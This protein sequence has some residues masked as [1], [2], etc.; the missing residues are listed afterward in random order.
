MDILCPEK[1]SMAVAVWHG[2]VG[3]EIV[4]RVFGLRDP[5]IKQAIYHHVLGDCYDPY[6][7]MVF[8]ADKT[9]PLRG[10]DST[11]MIE[12]CLQDLK[13]GFDIVKE[14]NENYLQKRRTD[15]IK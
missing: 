2:F 15:G 3:S 12:A 9:D 8:C 14:E 7:M 4:D 10:Y 11:D 1:K 13:S 6:A 5:Q